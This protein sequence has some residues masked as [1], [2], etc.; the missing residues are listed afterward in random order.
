MLYIMNKRRPEGPQATLVELRDRGL[1]ED[2]QQEFNTFITGLKVRYFIPGHPN[3][4]QVYRVKGV[5]DPCGTQ[6]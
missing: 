4:E 5:K 3:S 6:K 1:T 2:E